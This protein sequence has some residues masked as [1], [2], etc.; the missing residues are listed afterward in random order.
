[1]GR[2]HV[3]DDPFLARLMPGMKGPGA[4][5]MTIGAS[6][7]SLALVIHEPATNSARFGALSTVN[8]QIDLQCRCECDTFKIIGEM[9]AGR[10]LL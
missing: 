4:P 8:G 6:W 7:Q 9:L 10:H 2:G 3:N 5:S 1:L